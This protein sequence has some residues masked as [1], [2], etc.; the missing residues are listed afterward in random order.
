[1]RS[2]M[3]ASLVKGVR[4]SWLGPQK[5]AGVTG[6]NIY[7]GNEFTLLQTVRAAQFPSAGSQGSSISP[8]GPPISQFT[9][10]G[11]VTGVKTAFYVSCY[12]ALLES[13]KT[14]IIA[15]AS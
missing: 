3:A 15:A 11:L 2:L 13:I 8:N 12:T 4:L 5:L 10:N 7:E 6:Y 14:Q 9:V 1:V